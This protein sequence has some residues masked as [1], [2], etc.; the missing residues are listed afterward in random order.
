[1][2]YEFH[3]KSKNTTTAKVR[4]ARQTRKQTQGEKKNAAQAT[5]VRGPRPLCAGNTSKPTHGKTSNRPSLSSISKRVPNEIQGRRNPLAVPRC[6]SLSPAVPR[7][8]SLSRCVP[9]YPS[10][11][12]AVPRCPSLS[13][14]VPRCPSLSLVVPLCPSLSVAV[15]CCPSL[16]LAVPRCPSLSLVVLLCPSLSLAVPRCPLLSL[17]VPRVFALLYQL[18]ASRSKEKE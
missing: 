15:P 10:L 14:V 3:A 18:L 2:Q 9:R 6:P 17:A 11:S 16:S 8:P 7:C 4:H 12:L 13:L 1:M 5:T